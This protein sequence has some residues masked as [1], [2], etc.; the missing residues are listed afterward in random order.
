MVEFKK[1]FVKNSV[2]GAKARVYYSLDN[3]SDNRKCVTLY[4]KSYSDRLTPV[5]EEAAINN[6]DSMTDY[7]E[8]DKV[9]L[10]EDHPLYQKARSF[11][12]SMRGQK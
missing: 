7:F 1:H 5:F 12:E 11:V 3:R 10:F 9:V 8:T 4:A 6:S 2:T